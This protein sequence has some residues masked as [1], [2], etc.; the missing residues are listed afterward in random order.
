MFFNRLKIPFWDAAQ[1]AQDTS[2]VC[3][4]RC[5]NSPDEE[6]HQGK[7][8]A[9]ARFRCLLDVCARDACDCAT[10]RVERTVKESRAGR[11]N[12]KRWKWPHYD[13]SMKVRVKKNEQR[14]VR[15]VEKNGVGMWLTGVKT[16]SGKTRRSRKR[17]CDVRLLIGKRKKRL[18]AVGQH[19]SKGQ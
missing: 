19:I 12:T 4:T 7:P 10:V 11:D 8:C 9:I 6:V 5:K 3:A 18:S 2:G 16:V 14:C 13:Q 17:D 15:N 1:K